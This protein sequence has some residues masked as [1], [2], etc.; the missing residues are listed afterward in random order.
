MTSRDWIRKIESDGGLSIEE[1]TKIFHLIFISVDIA[2][3]SGAFA[4]EGGLWPPPQNTDFLQET[5]RLNT[6]SPAIFVVFITIGS[7]KVKTR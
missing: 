1:L 3:Q 6:I 2:P 5:N 4:F 7:M